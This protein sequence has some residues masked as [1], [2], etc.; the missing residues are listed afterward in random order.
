MPS[1]P[2]V[3]AGPRYPASPLG[4]Q[5]DLATVL[6]LRPEVSHVFTHSSEDGGVGAGVSGLQGTNP[7]VAGLEE[8][9]IHPSTSDLG[10][11]GGSDSPH[12]PPPNRSDP[13]LSLSFIPHEVPRGRVKEDRNTGV[14]L[15]DP[16]HD[17]GCQFPH[18]VSCMPASTGLLWG[19]QGVW[20]GPPFNHSNAS[21]YLQ[22]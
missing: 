19:L 17:Q 10:Y 18:H 1:S 3:P 11:T 15:N 9:P 22:G 8:A 5:G 2:V 4:S 14:K 6:A 13:F 16:A 20:V 12:S 7:E 21:S